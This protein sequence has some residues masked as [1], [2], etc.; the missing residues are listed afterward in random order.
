MPDWCACP[1]EGEPHV[2]ICPADPLLLVL[3]RAAPGRCSQ[4]LETIRQ[5]RTADHAF[6]RDMIKR[7]RRC[8]DYLTS[9]LTTNH[10]RD[11]G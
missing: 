10:D 6:L 8:I 5:K 11:G 4:A 9:K 1:G 7:Q 2:C 3:T